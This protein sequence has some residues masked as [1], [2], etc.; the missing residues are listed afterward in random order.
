MRP[1]GRTEELGVADAVRGSAFDPTLNAD[2][3]GRGRRGMRPVRR[4]SPQQSP[5][6]PGRMPLRRAIDSAPNN[7]NLAPESS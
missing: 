3:A 5:R 6:P 1:I 4:G 7:I 2:A